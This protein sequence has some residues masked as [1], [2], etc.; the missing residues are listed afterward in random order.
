[1]ATE[2]TEQ[3]VHEQA[4]APEY[5]EFENGLRY[6]K[7]FAAEREE[8][9]AADPF[10]GYERVKGIL[11]PRTEKGLIRIG[12]GLVSRDDSNLD[13]LW[14]RV[15]GEVWKSNGM[16]GARRLQ[17]YNQREAG[18]TRYEARWLHPMYSKEEIREVQRDSLSQEYEIRL[19]E[20]YDLI[21]E[22]FPTDGPGYDEVTGNGVESLVHTWL[23][24]PHRL[25]SYGGHQENG[26]WFVADPKDF[27]VTIPEFQSNQEWLALRCGGDSTKLK[28][29]ASR[30]GHNCRI[31]RQPIRGG[32]G[33]L[34]RTHLHSDGLGKNDGQLILVPLEIRFG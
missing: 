8:A 33:L 4:P 9:L 13:I 16:F 11:G 7:I 5:V 12:K 20:N 6:Q 23:R 31:Y 18:F 19:V 3:G 29:L 28:E 14:N 34:R 25:N 15:S 32:V 30:M 24:D 27:G 21:S 17:G 10:E 2:A 22:P 26:D 1:M